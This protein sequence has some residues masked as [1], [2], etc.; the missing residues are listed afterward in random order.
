[1]NLATPEGI[2]RAARLGVVETGVVG[3]VFASRLHQ[4]SDI[5]H[6]P[7]NQAKCFTIMRHPVKRAV[8]LFYYLREAST[9][10]SYD[11]GFKSMTIEEY[12]KSNKAESDWMTRSLTQKLSAPGLRD[13][14]LEKAK[15][16]LRTKC[17]IGLTNKFDESKKRFENYFGWDNGD[18]QCENDIMKDLSE[19]RLRYHEVEEGS[20][21]FTLLARRNKY[22]MKL[23]DYAVE[24]FEEQRS[25][26]RS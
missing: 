8:S 26:K 3:A 15:E 11:D 18:F 16:F 19:H 22:D 17:L 23:Y 4:V 2:E 25:I 12:A 5:F 20:P 24:L 14:D 9:E 13:E 10:K 21:T 7:D 6:P 1:M